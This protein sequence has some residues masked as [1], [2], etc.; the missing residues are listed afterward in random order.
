MMGLDSTW[1]S[2]LRPTC[3]SCFVKAPLQ[4]AHPTSAY[5][6][7][8]PRRSRRCSML[9]PRPALRDRPVHRRLAWYRRRAGRRCFGPPGE[10]RRHPGPALRHR[11]RTPHGAG[12]AQV[13]G[14]QLGAS[15]SAWRRYRYARR[16]QP[17]PICAFRA[18]PVNHAPAGPLDG[19]GQLD[20]GFLRLRGACSVRF[21]G[22]H[23]DGVD[24]HGDDG[25][26]CADHHQ[27]YFRQLCVE[28]ADDSTRSSG[29]TR[30]NVSQRSHGSA[31][32]QQQ[33]CA[34]RR[35]NSG[36][37]RTSPMNSN[38]WSART[39]PSRRSGARTRRTRWR[40]ERLAVVFEGATRVARTG[41]DG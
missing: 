39:Q 22:Q 27:A 16:G 17:A 21:G 3:T 40:L 38:A 8:K 1:G 19:V 36:V 18:G 37:C 33:L 31:G 32:T 10:H 15:R 14:D 7:T 41:H 9:C 23:C 25:Y 24:D 5:G 13:R 30:M 28:L 35:R 2:R 34:R 29:P 11:D 6:Q 12:S 4:R 20:I 26:G